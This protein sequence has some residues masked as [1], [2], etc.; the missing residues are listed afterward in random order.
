MCG[1]LLAAISR[2]DKF[3]IEQDHISHGLYCCFEKVLTRKKVPLGTT[4]Q[5]EYRRSSGR[6]P[7]NPRHRSNF[8]LY[9]A[10]KPSEISMLAG[11][12]TYC[13]LENKDQYLTSKSVPQVKS[14]ATL[15]RSFI[16]KTA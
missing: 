4:H 14:M 9:A 1:A 3:E 7:I 2:H 12:T 10:R 6:V 11:G 5:N 16:K 13:E 8:W 15:L